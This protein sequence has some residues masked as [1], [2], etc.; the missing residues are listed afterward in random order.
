MPNL[1]I[2]RASKV[3]AEELNKSI[4]SGLSKIAENLFYGLLFIGA[5]LLFKK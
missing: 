2:E 1:D 3:H 4:A 5:V